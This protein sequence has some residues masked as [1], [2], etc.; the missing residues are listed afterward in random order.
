M[1]RRSQKKETI[2]YLLDSGFIDHWNGTYLTSNTILSQT[3]QPLGD[4]YT[5]LHGTYTNTTVL[6]FGFLYNFVG[7][8]PLTIVEHVQDV[9]QQDWFQQVLLGGRTTLQKNDTNITYEKYDAIMVLAHM[10]CSDPLVSVIHD[11]I[12]AVV[13]PAMPVQFITGH[14]H[15]RKYSILDDYA[16]SFEAGRY[17]DTIGFV[18]FPTAGTISKTIS[19]TTSTPQME[20]HG[21]EPPNS[22]SSPPTSSLFQYQYIDANQRTLQNVLEVTTNNVSGESTNL[23]GN[24]D[25]GDD[26]VITST[27]SLWF[28]TPKGQQL[29]DLIH[30]TQHKLGLDRILGCSPQTYYSGVVARGDEYVQIPFDSKSSL[31]KL[32]LDHVIPTQLFAKLPYFPT[33]SSKKNRIFIQGTGIIRYHLFEGYVTLDDVIAVCPFNDTVYEMVDSI[34]GWQIQQTLETLQKQ[35]GLTPPATNTTTTPTMTTTGTTNPPT[36]PAFVSSPSMA[37]IRPDETY[38]LYVPDYDYQRMVH[39]VA[40]IMTGNNDGDNADDVMVRPVLAVGSTIVPPKPVCLSRGSFNNSS[41]D[42]TVVEGDNYYCIYTTD[43]WKTFVEEKMPCGTIRIPNNMN[44]HP[45][46]PVADAVFFDNNHL[47]TGTKVGVLLEEPHN[48]MLGGTV[49]NQK[50]D[51][52]LSQY[53]SLVLV[54]VALVVTASMWFRLRR[55][56]FIPILPE[57]TTDQFLDGVDGNLY[58]DGQETLGETSSTSAEFLSGTA[59]H[60]Q[61]SLYGS[62]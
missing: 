51:W 21:G 15:R 3:H 59:T 47:R 61:S 12:R 49:L 52:P 1:D 50:T 53:M 7:N 36:I 26:N 28:M 35:Y 38:T 37:D 6:T 56:V 55:R 8:C 13:G 9:V 31:W 10:D 18:S 14:S 33:N 19:T 30:E 34:Y 20:R 4:R 60:R 46:T 27:P 24:V 17:L 44:Q 39:V 29:S 48:K 43:L 57:V 2:Q 41:G 45:T 5:Y 40:N 22:S 25:D 11:A 32:Y 42:E 54:V 62:I 58:H 16:T 23:A